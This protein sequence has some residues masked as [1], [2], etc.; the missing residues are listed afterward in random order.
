MRTPERCGLRHNA[1]PLLARDER[2][3]ATQDVGFR[4]EAEAELIGIP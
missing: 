4:D 2:S 3:G 1:R